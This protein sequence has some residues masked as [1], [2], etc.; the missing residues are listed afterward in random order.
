MNKLFKIFLN[1][2]RS[3]SVPI[4]NFLITIIGIKY[5]GKENW[6]DFIQ[7]LLWIYFVVFI[8]NFGNKDYLLRTYSKKPSKI[9]RDFSIAFV[10]RTVFL[11]LSLFLFLFFSFEISLLGVLLSVLIYLY[12]SME[13]LVI[14]KQ[15]F[16]SQLIAEILGFTI[17]L[18]FVT[19]YNP[20]NTKVLL[21]AYCLAFLLKFIV[22]LVALKIDF[23][24]MKFRYSLKQIKLLLPFFLI[25]FSGWLASKIDL[26]M[27][28]IFLPKD[29]LAAY[30]LLMTAFLMLQAF[31]SFIIYPFTKHI[32]RLNKKSILKIK[33]ILLLVSLPLISICTFIIW[34]VLERI[35]KLDLSLELYVLGALSALPIFFFM[36]D[37]F[38][39]YKQGKEKIVLYINFIIAI[40]SLFLTLVLIPTYGIKGA[41]YSV[42]ISQFILLF[43]YKSNLFKKT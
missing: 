18:T 28:N 20:L 1:I 15:K 11:L 43:L 23:K 39:F 32:Y 7:V 34:F 33:R 21:I 2:A 31:A 36:I 26:Y 25:G 38:Q 19:Y 17:I 12:Q 27:V 37:I 5:L 10:S 22:V 14:Y 29:Q 24:Q 42:V 40:I 35:V 9:Y 8:S 30:Q 3:L 6:G 41:L 16:T 4:F 13:S